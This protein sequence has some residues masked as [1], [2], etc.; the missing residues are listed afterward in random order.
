MTLL[1]TLALTALAAA[2]LLAAPAAAHDP[3][4]YSF[5]EPVWISGREGTV[6]VRVPANICEPPPI[7]RPV[8]P[9]YVV[10][11]ITGTPR[12]PGGTFPNPCTPDPSDTITI[13][14]HDHTIAHPVPSTTEATCWGYFGFPSPTAPEGAV[15][16]S[17]TGLATHVLVGRKLRALSS[18]GPIRAGVARGLLQLVELGPGG[19]C[20]TTVPG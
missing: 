14:A 11:A 15:R 8:V 12:D 3:P 17:A 5:T 4:S 19:Q 1:R 2:T 9:L 13:P 20:W 10:G 18:A 16:V 6:F 7:T